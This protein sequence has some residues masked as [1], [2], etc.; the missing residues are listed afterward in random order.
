MENRP[1]LE[2]RP[3]QLPPLEILG[4]S[5]VVAEKRP[6]PPTRPKR[7]DSG[8]AIDFDDVPVDERPLGF[9]EI[10]AVKSFDERMA[11][12]K[13]T[14]DYWASADHGLEEWI[15]SVGVRRPL[16]AQV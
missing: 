15:G 3:S 8:T 2:K 11:L 13:R 14:R 4:S 1:A 6:A 5:R 7:A 10:V 9:K 12:Y 16:V